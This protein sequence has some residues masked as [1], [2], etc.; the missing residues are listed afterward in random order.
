MDNKLI[1][2]IIPAYNAHKTIVKTLSSIAC[3]TV[4]DKCKVTIVN[5]A[6]YNYA[7]IVESFNWCLSRNNFLSILYFNQRSYL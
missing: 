4:V 7:D 2:I 1:D 5:D 6:G 3:Q